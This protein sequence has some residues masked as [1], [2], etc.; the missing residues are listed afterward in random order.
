M[1]WVLVLLMIAATTGGDVFRAAG[2][3]QHGEIEDFRPGA[4]GRALRALVRNR[5]VMLS[6]LSMAVSFFSFI[7]LVS[8]APLSFA[9][10]VSA[11]TFVPETVLARYWLKE[12]VDWRRWTGAALI[13]IGVVLVSQ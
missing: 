5:F 2:M 1:K 3:K 12:A 9:V 6:T 10:P 8:I 13:M 11:A 4:V 7:K